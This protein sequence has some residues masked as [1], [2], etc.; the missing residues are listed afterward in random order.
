[1]RLQRV[2]FIGV[3]ALVSLLAVAGFA[4]FSSSNGS[5]A[6]QPIGATGSV[7][8]R[9]AGAVAAMGFAGSARGTFVVATTAPAT[10]STTVASDSDEE[11]TRR[12]T[13]TPYLRSDALDQI[14]VRD[15]LEAHFTSDDINRAMRVAWCES[16]FNPTLVDPIDGSTGLFPIDPTTWRRLAGAAD[17]TDPERNVQVAAMIVAEQGWTYWDCRG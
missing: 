2:A 12:S 5:S 16:G 15:L 14:E 1:M 8:G 11:P 4:A 6:D 7:A 10:P 13:G 3:W 17:P 9:Q